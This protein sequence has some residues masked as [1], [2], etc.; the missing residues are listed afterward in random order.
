MKEA[1]KKVLKSCAIGR[2]VYEPMH[3]MYLLW[4][5]PWYRYLFKRNGVK[6]LSHI[7][8]VIDKYDIP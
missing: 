3:R 6:T 4:A 8:K 7:L 5:I 1:V 2:L